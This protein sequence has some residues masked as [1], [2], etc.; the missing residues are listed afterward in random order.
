M[1]QQVVGLD[2]VV[3]TVRDLEASAQA[4]R[5]LGFTLS[6]RGTHSAHMGTGN[7]TI[8]FGDDYLEL[9]GVLA[10]TPHNEPTR[11][12]LRERE[13]IERA[14]FTA[15]DAEA[16]VEELK[17]EGIAATGPVDFG[18]PVDLPGGGSTTARFRTFNW[19]VNERPGGMRL[20]A[21]QHLTREAVWIPQ[22]QS[23]ANGAQRIDRVELLSRD[24]KAAAAQMG[25]LI[26][27]TA[28]A[29]GH[30]AWRMPS[31]STRADFVF[32]D[33]PALAARYPGV[34]VDA[35]ADEGAAAL[36]LRVA[37]LDAARAAIDPSVPA[38]ATGAALVV[39]PSHASGLLL[40]LTPF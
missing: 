8:M 20:F 6:P 3:I 37:D 13:G 28:E 36:V 15:V 32:L 31:G 12:F 34:P 2:H 21:C 29:N 35:L 14:A 7:Y 19:P 11:N 10:D 4:W 17:S 33:R 30:G 16:G 40:V 23:H 38:I 24:P 26:L 9:L 39:P 27:R 18:R 1:L 22:L 25:R 5:R